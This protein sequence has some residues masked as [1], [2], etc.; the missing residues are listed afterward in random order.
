MTLRAATQR[1]TCRACPFKVLCWE[2]GFALNAKSKAAPTQIPRVALRASP[3]RIRT[4]LDWWVQSRMGV[5]A[6]GAAKVD[7][8]PRR[9]NGHRAAKRFREAADA[10]N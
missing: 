4:C 9:R 7:I 5:G 3:L 6:A 8:T 2:I 1:F 10:S